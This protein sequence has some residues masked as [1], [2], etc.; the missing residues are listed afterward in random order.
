MVRECGWSGDGG[1]WWWWVVR[2]CGWSGDGGW[3][4]WWVVRECGW[5]GTA[6][7]GGGGRGGDGWGCTV[8]EDNSGRLLGKMMKY[9]LETGQRE[10]K[11]GERG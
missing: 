7:G 11:E 5:S 1:W 8:C 2:E 6:G 10:R 4:W 3:W 9:S